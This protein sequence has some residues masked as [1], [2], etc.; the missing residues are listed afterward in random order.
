MKKVL[1]ILFLFQNLSY[2]Q[3][4]NRDVPISRA[5]DMVF[6]DEVSGI[7]LGYNP[8][9]DYNLYPSRICKTIDGGSSW[10]YYDIPLYL[11]NEFYHLSTDSL[12]SFQ[13]SGNGNK[14]FRSTDFGE[15]WDVKLELNNNIADITFINKFDGFLVGGSQLFT[16]SN[17]GLSWSEVEIDDSLKLGF[18]MIHFLDDTTG[19]ISTSEWPNQTFLWTY[20]KGISWIKKNISIQ[21]PIYKPKTFITPKIGYITAGSKDV[22]KTTDGGITWNKLNSSFNYSTIGFI[23]RI[24]FLNENI[25]FIGGEYPN[26]DDDPT[27]HPCIYKTTDGGENWELIF[28]DGMTWEKINSMFFINENIGWVSSSYSF[29]NTINGGI[30][31][32]KEIAL[33]NS[34]IDYKLFQ[35]YPNPFNPSTVISYSIPKNDFVSIKIYD[36]IGKLVSTLINTEKPPGNYSVTF[37]AEALSSGV[38]FYKIRTAEYSETKKMLLLR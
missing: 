38:Y 35:N 25:G 3:W 30:T 10:V 7:A 12:F 26:S 2:S 34:R 24:A 18:K 11:G 37:N 23:N 15:N 9:D 31:D 28:K 21:L 1:V 4:N 36:S 16:T 20:N 17:S 8:D 27:T 5:F 22:Y 33:G 19:W 6:I 29:F 14:L 13:N 32:I